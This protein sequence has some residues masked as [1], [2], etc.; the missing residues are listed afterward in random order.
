[1]QKKYQKVLNYSMDRISAKNHE[2]EFLNL[3]YKKTKEKVWQKI[4]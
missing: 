1:M 3:E 4:L 2:V